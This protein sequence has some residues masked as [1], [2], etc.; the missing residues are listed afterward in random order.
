MKVANTVSRVAIAHRPRHTFFHTLLLLSCLTH[1]TFAQ[2]PS[3]TATAPG[4]LSPSTSPHQGGSVGSKAPSI[5]SITGASVGA[6]AG[7]FVIL[8]AVLFWRKRQQTPARIGDMFKDVAALTGFQNDKTAFGQS[9]PSK[10]LAAQRATMDA[11][12]VAAAPTSSA[13]QAPY[14]HHYNPQYPYQHQ[15]PY[16]QKEQQHHHPHHQQ[17]QQPGLHYA[18]NF[19]QQ[20]QRDCSSHSEG[21]YSQSAS[22]SNCPRGPQEEASSQLSHSQPSP[23]SEEDIHS[24]SQEQPS[25]KLTQPLLSDENNSS[26]GPHVNLSF[27]LPYWQPV[28]QRDIPRGPQGKPSSSRLLHSQPTDDSSLPRGPHAKLVTSQLSFSLPVNDHDSMRGPHAKR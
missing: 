8:V 20:D 3:A 19:D 27:Q 6:V 16:Q 15:Y 23:N 28:D 1:S 18:Y 21:R 26:R 13:S 24:K 9:D 14:Q 5:G 7:V 25:L 2:T 22:D 12:V 11:V 10:H 17:R 4:E